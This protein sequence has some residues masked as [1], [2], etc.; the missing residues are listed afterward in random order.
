MM[1]EDFIDL[2]GFMDKE[3]KPYSPA[4]KRLNLDAIPII[5]HQKILQ[6]QSTNFRINSLK[7]AESSFESP[8]QSKRY[9]SENQPPASPTSLTVFNSPAV[10]RKSTISIM[11]VLTSSSEYLRKNRM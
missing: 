6:P 4:R 11:N 3:N 2:C 8:V 7:R 10:N 1:D 9:K 5:P